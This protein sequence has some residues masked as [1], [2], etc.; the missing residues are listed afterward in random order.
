LKDVAFLLKVK[1]GDRLIFLDQSS[2]E[3]SG[4]A[5]RTGVLLAIWTVL[6]LLIF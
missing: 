2:V 6:K 4:E 3:G 1:L 5:G